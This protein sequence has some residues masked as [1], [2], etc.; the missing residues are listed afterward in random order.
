MNCSFW[1]ILLLVGWGGLAYGQKKTTPLKDLPPCDCRALDWNKKRRYIE[2]GEAAEKQ[3]KFFL[4]QVA[5][6]SSLRLPESPI[7]VREAVC[8]SPMAM[9][10]EGDNRLILFN[11]YFI[12]LINQNDKIPMTLVDKHI[13]AHELGHHV[14]GHFKRLGPL[15]KIEQLYEREHEYIRR[16]FNLS[17]SNPM[18]QE[19]EADLFALWLLSKAE[20]NFDV[21]KLIAQMDTLRLWQEDE[22]RRADTV[23]KKEDKNTAKQLGKSYGTHPFFKDRIALMRKY[24]ELVRKLPATVASRGFAEISNSAYFDLWPS[25]HYLDISVSAGM[26]LAGSPQFSVQG[27]KVPAFLYQS[28]ERPSFQVGFS[29][30]RFRWDKPLFF[31]ADLHWN[32]QHYGTTIET[33]DGRKLAEK[34][35]LDYVSFCPQVGWNTA[36]NPRERLSSLKMGFVGSIGLNVCVPLR[37]MTYTNYLISVAAPTLKPSIAPRLSLGFARLRKSIAP[38]HWKLLFNYEF[39]CLR[40]EANPTPRAIS[41]NFSTTLQYTIS[42]R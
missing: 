41:H 7:Q 30:S 24:Q 32:Q 13:L 28:Q 26:I 8:E 35:Q 14:L 5:N 18:A 27:Q 17:S 12:N 3:I 40:L 4:E 20:K 22:K 16:H 39:Q 10:C 23:T 1:T 34:F 25:R 21:K 31:A 29:A 15:S 19:I 37:D 9:L 36:M 42:R 6:H 11:D 38:R 2:S 33:E